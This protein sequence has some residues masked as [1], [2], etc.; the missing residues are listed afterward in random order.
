ME[1]LLKL[2]LISSGVL[3]FLVW[4]VPDLIVLGFFLLILPGLIL[5]LIPTAF[6]YL[7]V[8]SIVWFPT[9]RRG[10]SEAALY[11]LL[12]VASFALGLPTLLNRTSETLLAEAR[13]SDRQPSTPVSIRPFVKIALPRG[14]AVHGCDEL[15]QLLLF[16]DEAEQVLITSAQAKSSHAFRL[17]R[18]DCNVSLPDLD[19]MF[20]ASYHT[21]SNAERAKQVAQAARSRI[22]AGECLVSTESSLPASS[23]EIRWVEENAN[24]TFGRLALG[25]RPPANRG[26]EVLLEGKLVA[27]ETTSSVSWLSL[28]LHFEPIS[29]GLGFS[30]W[31]WARQ[32]D[33][34]AGQ[35]LDRLAMLKRLSSFDLEIPRGVGLS[36][37]RQRL[38]TA[39]ANPTGS[40]AAFVL[41]GEYYKSLREDGF[42]VRDRER[43]VKLILDDRVTDFSYF[44]WSKKQRQNVGPRIRD[45]MLQRLLRLRDRLDDKTA[46]GVF[47]SLEQVAGRLG[48]GSYADSPPVLDEL[49]ADPRAR[50][51]MPNLIPR[52]AD[53]GN[54]GATKL[55]GLI[56]AA[57]LD[58]PRDAEPTRKGLCL[59]ANDAREFLPQLRRIHERA[60]EASFARG[61][62]WRGLLIALGADP[63]EFSSPNHPDLARYRNELRNAAQHC[64]AEKLRS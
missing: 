53:Q 62:N 33:P 25:A 52:L 55:V 50:R 43:L 37:L 2:S 31:R 26:V 9:R 45:A 4:N 16:N 58:R 48:A 46:R 23:I 8:F 47:H 32:K 35:P 30:G 20:R 49:L 10:L 13:A 28:P 44:D 15:C 12:A 3:T 63:S 54:A 27:R 36:S 11:G 56:D 39:L 19:K 42:D 64:L 38:D 21:W 61:H 60:G 41:L 34:A 7:C 59:I 18:D 57:I 22:A 17:L 24:A 14:Q 51:Y 29:N 40:N 1:R 5:S 6:L